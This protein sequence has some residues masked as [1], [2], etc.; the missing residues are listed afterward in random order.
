M[1]H[2][3]NFHEFYN[4]RDCKIDF[5]FLSCVLESKLR[6]LL[7]PN[8]FSD[9]NACSIHEKKR[10]ALQCRGCYREK[11]VHSRWPAAREKAT[12]F[13][14]CAFQPSHPQQTV[15]CGAVVWGV[16]C[17]GM[18]KVFQNDN[19]DTT[20]TFLCDAALL[21]QRKN[22]TRTT[23]ATSA[24]K[25]NFGAN[26]AN[27]L[28]CKNTKPNFVTSNECRWNVILPTIKSHLS[29]ARKVTQVNSQHVKQ[30]NWIQNK[31]HEHAAS[32]IRADHKWMW[33]QLKLLQTSQKL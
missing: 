26:Q 9:R 4:S 11:R 8:W 18:G 21:A 25:M 12:Q 7:C 13:E 6:N 29:Y 2:V 17:L 32:G 31:S 33:A 27:V 28:E 30:L 15:K 1:P 20:L 14:Q 10:V 23:K 5:V 19:D 24:L 3:T 16:F 22:T